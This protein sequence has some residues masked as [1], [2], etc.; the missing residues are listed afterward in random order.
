MKL[1]LLAGQGDLPFAVIEGALKEGYEVCVASLEFA[2]EFKV[3][4]QQFGLGDF[5]KI[6]K[7]FKK[8]KVSH[9]CFAGDVTR[10]NFKKLR[11]D[12]KTLTK[13]PG[14]LKA[15]KE[16]D[17][18]LLRYVVNT[19][20]KEGFSIVSPQEL[21]QNLLMPVGHI[22]EVELSKSHRDDA[23]K[24]MKT[25]L[26]IGKLDIGQGAVVCRGLV[27]AVEAQEGTDAM[28]SRVA[29]LSVE[30]RG[31]D[32]VR[33]GVLA[34]MVKPGQET[35]VDLPTIGPETIR[36]AAEAGLAGIIVES[37]SAFVIRKGEVITAAD[38]AGMFV[39]G[40]PPAEK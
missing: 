35:R 34:K 8:N 5:G 4:S 19:F 40:L 9:V 27:L 31:T 17:D 39:V 33:A 1:G 21:C 23:E 24:A 12:F 26:E 10:P 11:P 22:G 30:I 7:Y 36:R 32:K 3:E 20:E 2:G 28:L 14:A 25:A 16:G 15:A 18:A 29:S 37:G 6:T 13:L 38:A